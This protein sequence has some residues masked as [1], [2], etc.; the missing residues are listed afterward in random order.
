MLGDC[1]TTIDRAEACLRNGSYNEFGIINMTLLPK[2]KVD[3]VIFF[4]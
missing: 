1:T 4:F 2:P 3:H